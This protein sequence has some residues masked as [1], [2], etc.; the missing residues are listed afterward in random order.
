MEVQKDNLLDVLS[1]KNVT[2]FI[3]PY[4]RNYDWDDS[5]CERFF[6]D[7][8]EL[9]RSNATGK[10]NKHFFGSIVYFNSKASVLNAPKKCILID[11]QQRITTTMLFLMAVRDLITNQSDKDYINNNYLKNDKVGSNDE[12]FK[13]KLK[14]VEADWPTYRSLALEI[15]IN[16]NEKNTSVYRNYAFF[17]NKLLQLK[18]NENFNIS[19]LISVGLAGFFVIQIVLEPTINSWENPQEIFESLNS[20]G[21]PLSFADLVRNY[22]LMGKDPNK[23]EQLYLN[24][25]LKMEQS[26]KGNVSFYIRDFMQMKF[27]KSFKKPSD[28]NAKELY[29]DFKACFDAN[30]T[31]DVIK[32]LFDYSYDYVSITS[33]TEV[34]GNSLVDKYLKDFKFL[35]TTS[36]FPLFMS[37][38]HS[39][40]NGKLSD[41]DYA[42][43]IHIFNIYELRR[44]IL[45]LT[46]QEN[47]VFPTLCNKIDE[48]LNSEDKKGKIYQII[49]GLEYNLRLPNDEELIRFIYSMNFYNFDKCKYFLALIEETLTKAQ[50]DIDNDEFLQIEH[51]MPQT[52]NLTWK[53]ELGPNADEIHDTYVNNIGNLTLIRHNQSL[54]NKSFIDKKDIYE[55]KAGLQI[56]KSKIIDK[57]KWTADEIE[58]RAQWLIEDIIVGQILVVPDKYRKGN[59]YK[60]KLA[61]PNIKTKHFS[62]AALGLI[63]ET[64]SYIGDDTIKAK[65]VSDKEVEFE[66]ENWKLS[67]LTKEIKRRKGQATPSE[68]YRGSAY[69]EWDGYKL[70]N[71]FFDE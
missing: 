57:D 43:I 58:Q 22:L 70:S 55:N 42:D 27:A 39:W 47:K 37:L 30:S 71:L 46:K 24:Y 53:K 29:A 54:S 23:Q 48:I 51:I 38:N 33:Q 40:R 63:G 49:T 15:K 7:V 44:R 3:P 66:G 12:E 32:E 10:E 14:Q 9:T 64:I 41:Q 25:W 11:G 13:I 5:Q 20:L 1:N 68:A 45:R 35:N 61:S 59:N 31:E 28:N 26:L 62:F 17:K 4:Q 34:V 2:F 8:V 52:L 18:T 6:N 16:D 21:K 36:L 19:S 69:W 67:P 50:P 60:I 56:A 65:V